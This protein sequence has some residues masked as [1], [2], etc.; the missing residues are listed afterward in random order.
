MKK[1]NL[2]AAAVAMAVSGG[3]NAAILNGQQTQG[4]APGELFV[5]VT[6]TAAQ[7]S[8]ALD[9]G[10]TTT[11]FLAIEATGSLSYD[12][13]S[14]A[15]YSHFMST[16]NPLVYNI[17]GFDSRNASLAGFF[18]AAMGADVSGAAGQ[19]SNFVQNA[20]QNIASH[21]AGLNGDAG[22][23]TNFTENFAGLSDGANGDA[24]Y[25]NASTWGS[26]MGGSVPFSTFV[27]VGEDAMFYNMGVVV[28]G[29]SVMSTVNPFTS[30]WNLDAAGQLS[31]GSVSAVPVPA[32]VWLFGS[33]LVGLVGVARR[34][35]N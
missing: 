9:L 16:A 13:A 3:A 20:G 4:Q 14:Y 6:D 23:L 17:A 18:T 2:V 34:R 28:N 15:E 33:G 26:S 21:I 24:G 1:M 10:M 12:L 25:G 8:F 11:D 5:V 30:T 29:R 19:S 35:A 27:N 32:A 31:Y 22:T 7:K